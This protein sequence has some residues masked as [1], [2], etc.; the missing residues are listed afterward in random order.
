MALT[1]GTSRGHLYFGVEIVHT[2]RYVNRPEVSYLEDHVAG[3]QDL[4]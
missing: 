2:D 3:S 1:V 4:A